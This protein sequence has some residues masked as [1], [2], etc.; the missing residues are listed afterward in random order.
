M[1]GAVSAPPFRLALDAFIAALDD[2]V[3]VADDGRATDLDR[4]EL[5]EVLHGVDQ[6]RNRLPLIDHALI[7]AAERQDL[8]PIPFS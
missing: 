8:A 2:L 3:K 4:V 7:H 5:V 1:G 6:A